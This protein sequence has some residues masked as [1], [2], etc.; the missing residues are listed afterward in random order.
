MHTIAKYLLLLMLCMP[1]LAQ[2][3]A[4]QIPQYPGGDTALVNSI[5]SHI[6]YPE[7]AVNDSL[8]GQVIAQFRVNASG[9]VDSVWV[10]Q[11][12]SHECD[13]AVVSAVRALP[14]FDPAKSGGKPVPFVYTVP[15]DFSLIPHDGRVKKDILVNVGYGNA[16]VTDDQQYPEYPGGDEKLFEFIADHVQYPSQD[17]VQGKVYMEVV[18]T[19]GGQVNPDSLRVERVTG[20]LGPDYVKA[21]AAVLKSLPAFTP[22]KINGKPVD[23]FLTIPVT[24]SK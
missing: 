6:N 24:F 15:V 12:L 20:D 10:T 18:I 11:S 16:T 2:A 17:A 23:S 13:S 3:A 8:Q 14:K 7:Q 22:A 19:A 1:A 5:T 9:Q 4:N 21:A